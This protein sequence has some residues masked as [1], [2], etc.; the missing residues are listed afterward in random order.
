VQA[1]KWVS[2]RIPAVI[3]GKSPSSTRGIITGQP[4]CASKKVKAG[5][6]SS[7]YSAKA[8]KK[9]QVE[10]KAAALGACRIMPFSPISSLNSKKLSL[11]Y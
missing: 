3:M 7:G 8:H 6:L 2:E 11:E 5:A 4:R 10:Q 9:G 1:D